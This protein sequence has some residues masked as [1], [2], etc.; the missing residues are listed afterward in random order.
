MTI[1]KKIPSKAE[2]AAESERNVSAENIPF[3]QTPVVHVLSTID[4]LMDNLRRNHIK[5]IN[6][7]W[8]R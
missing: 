8:D 6:Y 3:K 1:G 2:R 5:N 7:P 4:V